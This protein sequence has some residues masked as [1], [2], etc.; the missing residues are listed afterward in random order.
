MSEEEGVRAEAA[1]RTGWVAVAAGTLTLP[2][3]VPRHTR[4]PAP[5]LMETWTAFSLQ[6]FFQ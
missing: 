4:Q 3:G 5:L 1:A 6:H 2:S